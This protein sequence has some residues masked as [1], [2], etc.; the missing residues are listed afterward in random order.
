MAQTAYAHAVPVVRLEVDERTA[1]IGKVY[2]YFLLSLLTAAC[3]VM[4]GLTT[5]VLQIV[6]EHY[7]LFCFA[8]IGLLFGAGR[9]MHKPGI[10]KIVLFGF[11]FLSGMVLGPL[12]YGLIA[13]A[14]GSPLLIYKGLALTG[15]IFFGLTVYVFVTRTDFSYLGSSLIVGLITFL[16]LT[17]LYFVFP[18]STFDLV[19]TGIGAALFSGFVLY[20]TSRI[21]RQLSQ[22]QYIDG[23][24]SLY[25]DFLNLFLIILNFVSGDE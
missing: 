3:G 9:L 1:F 17:L 8:E 19:I 23:A 16:A 15:C 4:F 12:F 22:D 5:M 7:V 10:N 2:L 21:M 13:M 25:I 20:D 18:S 6:S 14:G 24:L 11:A